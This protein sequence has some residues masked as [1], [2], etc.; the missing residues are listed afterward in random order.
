[1]GDQLC[2]VF[3][4]TRI[5][6]NMQFPLSFLMKMHESK[7]CKLQKQHTKMANMYTSLHRSQIERMLDLEK[8][9]H[10]W[11]IKSI[12]C[13][14]FLIKQRSSHD[15]YIQNTKM[16]RWIN[17]SASASPHFPGRLQFST[18]TNMA[19]LFLPLCLPFPINPPIYIYIYIYTN[20]FK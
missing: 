11:N 1:M 15:T 4:A 12:K 13:T 6:T 9:K 19:S 10:Y 16:K 20:I 3:Q 18:L 14:S 8:W 7:L 17:L 2:A 5:G